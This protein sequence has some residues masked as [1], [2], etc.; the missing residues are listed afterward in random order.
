MKLPI[1]ATLIGTT[2]ATFVSTPVIA[3][4][5]FYLTPYIGYSF[6]NDISDE[7]GIKVSIEDDQHF[8]I[9]LD[10]DMDAGRV[11]LFVSHQP[12]EVEDIEGDSSFTYVHFQSSLR[13]NTFSQ[14]DTFFGASIG[15]TIV[16]ADWTDDDMFFSAGLFGGAE[17][18]ISNNTR[19]VFEGRWLANL[20]DSDNSAICNLPTGNESCRIRIDS[21][22]L[23]QFQT[24]IGISFSF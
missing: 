7:D 6:S 1:I 20:V 23:S 21:E 16:D 8:A 10:T 14:G 19:I 17:Y 15:T 4:N 3:S 24:N 2:L 18:K 13:F 11:G 22:W 9:G 12:N 5:T